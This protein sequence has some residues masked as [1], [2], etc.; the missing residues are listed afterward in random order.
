MVAYEERALDALGDPN[1]RMVFKRLRGALTACHAPSRFC[2][3]D[4][5]RCESGRPAPGQYA[6]CLARRRDFV[7][8]GGGIS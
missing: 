7:H 4:T 2:P 3:P 6:G 8:W 5:D 1:R